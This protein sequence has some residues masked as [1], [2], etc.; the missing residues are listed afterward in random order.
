MHVFA[1][2]LMCQYYREKGKYARHKGITLKLF[3]HVQYDSFYEMYWDYKR[4]PYYGEQD[5]IDVMHCFSER[6]VGKFSLK[7]VEMYWNEVKEFVGRGNTKHYGH[8]AGALKEI[9]DIISGM[10][11]GRGGIGSF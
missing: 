4:H 5:A 6:F 11:S 1:L 8:V 9:R 3:S 10:R 7:V 2:E